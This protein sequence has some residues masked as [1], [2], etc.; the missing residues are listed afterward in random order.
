MKITVSD[1]MRDTDVLFS[2]LPNG[3]VSVDMISDYE[4]NSAE[5][6]HREWLKIIKFIESEKQEKEIEEEKKLSW[7]KKI[8]L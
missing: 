2:L 1:I 3:N 7:I 8:L 4:V 6:N 5:I